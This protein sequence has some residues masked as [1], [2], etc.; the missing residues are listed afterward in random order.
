MPRGARKRGGFFFD[1]RKFQRWNRSKNILQVTLVTAGALAFCL[2]KRQD[3]KKELSE[4][5]ICYI[6]TYNMLQVYHIIVQFF[7][8]PSWH[9]TNQFSSHTKNASTSSQHSP[10]VPCVFMYRCNFFVSIIKQTPC[11]QPSG[12][13]GTRLG[14]QKLLLIA[15]TV[16]LSCSSLGFSNADFRGKNRQSNKMTNKIKII[17]IKIATL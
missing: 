7:S 4:N 13:K 9:H 5:G 10:Q 12:V 15:W 3:A 14:F 11:A 1:Q 2:S 16:S 17:K 6:A 8:K